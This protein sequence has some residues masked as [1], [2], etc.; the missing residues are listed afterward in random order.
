MYRLLAIVLLACSAAPAAAQPVSLPPAVKKD[1]QCFFLYAAAVGMAEEEDKR[2]AGS[3]GV[4]YYYGR[5]KTAAPD[6]DLVQAVRQE[7]TLVADQ[8]EAEKIGAGC[9]AEVA[10]M[11][12]E[13]IKFGDDLKTA[14]D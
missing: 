12:N 4:A 10:A 6:L 2:N 13:L 14:S 11:G 7:M 1:V 8:A 3:I 5:L 9:D